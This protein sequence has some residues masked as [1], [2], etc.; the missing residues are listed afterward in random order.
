MDKAKAGIS[1]LNSEGVIGKGQTIV[2]K[3]TGNP[4]FVDLQAELPAITTAINNLVD[5]NNEA[6]FVGGKIAHEHKRVCDATLRR[7]INILLPQVQTASGGDAVKKPEHGE[8]PGTPQNFKSLFTAYDGQ[9]KMHWKGD[10][11]AIYY[12]LE[13]LDEQGK[14]IVVATTSRCTCTVS[15][16]ASGKACTFRVF[17]MGAIGASPVSDSVTAKAA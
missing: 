5:A 15:G 16:L 7:L 12:Q 11:L 9:V 2:E 14:W 1:R 10:K 3:M 17:A 13:M 8:K 4:V 6:K